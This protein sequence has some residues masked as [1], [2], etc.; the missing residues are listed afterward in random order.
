MYTYELDVATICIVH[1]HEEYLK[2][3][4]NGLASQKVNFRYKV[5]VYDN[6]STDSSKQI[7][8]EMYNKYPEIIVP[9]FEKEYIESRPYIVEKNIFPRFEANYVAFCEGD[10]WWCALG[11]L[12]AQYDYMDTNADCAVCAHNTLVHNIVTDEKIK[13]FNSWK[14]VHQLTPEEIFMDY[15]VHLSSFL[16]RMSVARRTDEVLKFP[17]SSYVFLAQAFDYG[18]VVSLPGTMS[19]YN[20]KENPSA[21]STLPADMNPEY[22]G[23]DRIRFLE[24]YDRDTKFKHK[25]IVG[26]AKDRLRFYDALLLLESGN[27]SKEDAKKCKNIINENS[28]KK[29]Y[30]SKLG[31]KEKLQFFFKTK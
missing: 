20:V 31:T 8:E 3:C 24:I 22:G 13:N 12:Q 28:Y 15:K 6:A 17:F 11:K 19:I 25:R 1:N 7:I 16:V 9:I 23:L 21:D 30:V 4:L 14:S 2:D 27:L 5:F 29:T 26:M 18:K 10:E